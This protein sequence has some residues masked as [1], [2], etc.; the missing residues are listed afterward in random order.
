MNHFKLS[1]LKS[2][3]AYTIANPD[4]LCVI[5]KALHHCIVVMIARQTWKLVL[6]MGGRRL[7]KKLYS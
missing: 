1:K 5:D 4:I 2:Q 7:A 3:N 6:V